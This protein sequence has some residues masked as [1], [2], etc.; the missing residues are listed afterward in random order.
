MTSTRSNL[1]VFVMAGGSGE[2]FWPLSRT[3]TPKH[4]LKLFSEQSLLQQT[5]ARLENL[6][7]KNQTFI[8]INEAQRENTV[9]DLSSCLDEKQIICEPAKRDTAPAAS[10]ATALAFAQNKE[11]VVVLLPADQL[12][13]NIR[14]FQSN[15]N[16]A[17]KIAENSEALITLGIPPTFASTGFGYLEK[18][19]ILPIGPEGTSFFNVSRFVE[20]PNKSE[21]EMYFDSGKFQWNA[22]IFVWKAQSFLKIAE[23][24]QTELANFI[25]AFPQDNVASYLDKNFSNLPK[26]SVD[27][28]IMEKASEVIM[29]QADFDWDDVGAWNALTPHLPK[30]ENENVSRG[31]TATHDSKGNILFSTGRTIAA[32]GIE[33]MIVVET[34]DAV[35]I[36]PKDRAQEVKKILPSL[37]D[38]VL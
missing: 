19:E 9:S 10:L 38:S 15:I 3:T 37:P 12:I 11:A 2:R 36:C 28:A 13:K 29:G 16:D 14:A 8:L 22:G 4:L 25:K 30:D 33:N 20:K 21:A 6:V 18:G 1:Y 5:V 7:S 32:C 27:Y 24:H 35:L 17:A 31:L 23:E 34:P 26:I